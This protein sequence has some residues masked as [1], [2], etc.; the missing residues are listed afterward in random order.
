MR[1][2]L[3]L[4]LFFGGL[5]ALGAI[6]SKVQEKQPK[7]AFEVYMNEPLTV[8]GLDITVTDVKETKKIHK[9]TAKNMF[10]QVFVT[11]KNTKSTENYVPMLALIN[12]Q[13]DNWNCLPDRRFA[14]D[15]KLNDFTDTGFVVKPNAE[16]KAYVPFACDSY[17]NEK[18]GPRKSKP[19]DFKMMA[20][21]KLKKDGGYIFLEKRP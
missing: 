2:L 5:L 17:L 19:A 15:D 7:K 14:L 20:Y 8:T 16:I 11:I 3:W 6:V 9:Y 1:A 18:A 13:D 12:R 10:V 21:N 4:V